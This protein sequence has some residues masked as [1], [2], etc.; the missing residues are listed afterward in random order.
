MKILYVITQLGL[1][2]AET[3]LVTMANKMAQKGYDVQVISLLNICEHVFDPRVEVC[4]LDFKNRFFYS[5]IQL[6]TII[7]KRSPDI[8]HSHCLHANVLIRLIRLS[9][10]R[11]KKLISTSHSPFEGD[12][13][14]MK[15]YKYTNF[16]SD[17]ITNVSRHAVKVFE[18]KGYVHIGEMKVM[19]N[20]IDIEK[21]KYSE[22]I[23]LFQR[24]KF[25]ISD[26][27]KVIIS[28][29]TMKDAKDYPNL[30]NAINIFRK[31]NTIDFRFYIVGEGELFDEMLELSSSL[32]LNDVVY[33]LGKRRDI[34]ELLCMSD[35]FVL[36]SKYEGLPTVLIEAI[37]ANN[38][39]VS[40][41]CGGV[42]EILP[43][44]FRTVEIGNPFNLAQ[45]IGRVITLE[46]N[47]SE[48][49]KSILLDF[50]EDK[51]SSNNTLNVWIELYNS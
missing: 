17:H 51:F 24:N 38:Y 39:I 28:I 29:G 20:I 32:K 26:Q 37:M 36:S 31:N 22:S 7:R 12:G 1:G 9:G 15:I 43:T 46:H 2:G 21:F 27:E 18:E 16:I 11:I 48:F 30:L 34:Y 10:I 40:T 13:V 35:I 49:D 47:V 19:Y 4:V 33:F 42:S 14:I 50:V 3:V 41:N 6:I 8:V 25:N 44:K 5:L 45:E 23:R